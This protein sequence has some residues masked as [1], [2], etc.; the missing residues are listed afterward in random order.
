MG[1]E[2]RASGTDWTVVRPPRLLNKP[3]TGTY[4]TA[5]GANLPGGQR[6]ARADLAHAMLAMAGD[7]AVLNRTVGVA[8]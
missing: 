4:R 7:G 6:I 1:R 5:A 8:C 2:M 3:L